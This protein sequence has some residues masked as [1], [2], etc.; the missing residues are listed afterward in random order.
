MKLFAV[1]SLS[2]L[3]LVQPLSKMLIV[4]EYQVNKNYIATVLCINKSKPQLHCEGKC[5]LTKQLAKAQH[6]ETE[7]PEFLKIKAELPFL[8]QAFTA[9]F[10]PEIKNAPVGFAPYL[11]SAKTALQAAVFHPPCFLV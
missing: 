8:N 10:Y 11:Q 6:S 3:M 5:Q 4:A 7:V 2:L 9:I 1:I